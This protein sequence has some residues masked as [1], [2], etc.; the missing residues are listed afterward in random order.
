MSF[1]TG[2]IF[3]LTLSATVLTVPTKLEPSL[4]LVKV[5]MVG[6]LLDRL[7]ATAIRRLSSPAAYAAFLAGQQSRRPAILRSRYGRERC[8]AIAPRLVIAIEAAMARPE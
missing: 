3:A 6:L 4:D 1:S 8:G 5:P 2:A 7:P